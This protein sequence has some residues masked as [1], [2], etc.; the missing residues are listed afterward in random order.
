[1]LAHRTL[2]GNV[3][4]GSDLGWECGNGEGAGRQVADGQAPARYGAGG[5]DLANCVEERRTCNW[6]DRA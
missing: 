2:Q 6:G 1:M 4:A 3:C 5:H